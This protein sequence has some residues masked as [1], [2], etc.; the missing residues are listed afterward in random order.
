MPAHSQTMYRA[1]ASRGA[2]R[3]R[4]RCWDR[5]IGQNGTGREILFGQS[6]LWWEG[7]T[8]NTHRGN[9]NWAFNTAY[10]SPLGLD[11]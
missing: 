3:S 11:A 9:V 4:S 2:G 10:A 8:T 1:V 6:L 5:P 7:H